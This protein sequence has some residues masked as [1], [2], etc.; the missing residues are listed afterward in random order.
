MDYTEIIV[1]AIGLCT[2]IVTAIVVPFIKSKIDDSKLAKNV[3]LVYQYV[4]AVEQLCGAGGGAEKKAKVI[5]MLKNAGVIVDENLETI[6]EAA[7]YSLNEIV[8]AA[9][10]TSDKG[11]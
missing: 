5:Q 8:S 3:S 11:E 2:L 1:S 10:T 4:K 6:I 9:T 7:V